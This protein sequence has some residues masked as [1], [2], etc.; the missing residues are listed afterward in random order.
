MM[1]S[2]NPELT[3]GRSGLTPFLRACLVTVGAI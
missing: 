2:T 3:H 1:A